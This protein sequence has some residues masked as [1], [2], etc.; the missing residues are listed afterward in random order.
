MILALV[1][2]ALVVP[3]FAIQ[4]SRGRLDWWNGFMLAVFTLN[5]L[6]FLRRTNV[7]FYE[8]GIHFP[9]ESRDLPDLFIRWSA[10]GRYHWEGDMLIVV[11]KLGLLDGG[12]SI[13]ALTGSVRVPA[14]RRVQVENL[15]KCATSP[16]DGGKST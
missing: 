6:V 15:L 10:I 1:M 12:L 16:T 14:S 13:P 5:A 11:E 9:A 7:T 4:Y 8:R 3:L 2:L